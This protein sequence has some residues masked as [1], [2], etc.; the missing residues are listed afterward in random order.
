MISRPTKRKKSSNMVENNTKT[1][2][3]TKSKGLLSIEKILIIS[4]KMLC[5]KSQTKKTP[6]VI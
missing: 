4:G 3:I 5:S 6:F 1:F 2:L